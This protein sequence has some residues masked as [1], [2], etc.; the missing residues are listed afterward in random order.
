MSIT[1]R[2]LAFLA[3]DA[4]L[5]LEKLGLPEPAVKICIAALQ[6]MEKLL[7]RPPRVAVMGEVN[8][9][10]TSVA[11]LLLGNSMLPASVV[12]NTH[13]PISI[14]YGETLTLDAV[15]QQGRHRLTDAQTD[16]LPSGL[17]LRRIEIGLPEDRLHTFE[18]L[19][20]PSGYEPAANQRDAQI[21]LW[22]TVASRAWTESERAR[23]SAMPKRCWNNGLLVITHKDAISSAADLAKIEQRVRRST[24]GMFRDVIAVSAAGSGRPM[25]GEPDMDD[26]ADA[27][28][29]YIWAQAEQNSARR[30]R[31]AERIIRHIARLTFHHLAPGPLSYEAAAILK[32]WDGDSTRL[33]DGIDGT[34]E[35]IARVVQALLE[36]FAH[37]LSEARAGR[38]VTR[39]PVASP[40]HAP[41]EKG[42][43]RVA[44]ARRYVRLI[45]ADLTAL[46]RIDLA[47]W[48]L[49]DTQ[50]VN[51]YAEARAA[52]LP[53]ANLDATFD[54]LGRKFAGEKAAA[55]SQP[56]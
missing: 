9:G 27:L 23:W 48:G 43:Y 5:R 24:S 51:A 42:P 4:R 12:S 20:T 13:V 28:L 29:Q 6:R 36:R 16:G 38:I 45:A 8:S 47:Q 14:S 2:E 53:L 44:A 19:D 3:A 7:A 46:L 34:P 22:C 18:I 11:D 31:K 1:A 37:S 21:F 33:L 10:K 54:E 56:A 40:G 50:R 49:P 30:A 15:T 25:P 32:A 39:P 35:S 17:Q 26:G 41:P 55:A 52:L